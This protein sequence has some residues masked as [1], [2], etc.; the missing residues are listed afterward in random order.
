[1]Q[2]KSSLLLF[3]MLFFAN[4]FY[5]Q[6]G[7]GTTDPSPA[8]MLEVSSQSNG[9][10]DYK[11]FMPPR[12][13]NIAARDAIAPTASDYGLLVFVENTGAATSCLQLWIGDS[14]ADVSCYAI[15]T[16]PVATDVEV[17]GT[18][19]LGDMVTASFSYSDADGDPAGA[20]TYTWYI[21][22]DALG[23]GQT[24][25]QTGTSDTYTILA[26]HDTKYIA[27]AVTPVATSGASPGAT[28][29]SDYRGP[30]SDG[31]VWPAV[32]NFEITPAAFELPLASQTNGYF[33]TGTGSFPS[34]NMFVSP[35]RGYGA[36]NETGTVTLGPIDVSSAVDATFRLRL[37]S[38]AG[39][40]GN[41]ADPTDTVII[42]VST[43][44]GSTYSDELLVK[45][46][47]INRRWDFSASGSATTGYTGTNTAVEFASPGGASGISS[48]EITGI[49][50]AANLYIKVEMLNNS[51]NE[52]WVID[53]AEIWG[54]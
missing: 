40:S 44:G 30:I 5:A 53:D 26:A 18:L 35:D 37:A 48:L 33:T 34:S 4:N 32:Q 23:T 1:M 24:L 11:G 29:L 17:I 51:N 7:I 3:A 16:P 12:V 41:G 27:V 15:N 47:S 10:G 13:P 43:D 49:P 42:S 45:G 50:N 31:P 39:S 54:N 38:F 21:A 36:N 2:I 28:V 9:T 14:W 25:V 8:A 22:D 46:N 20:H 6:V 52:T 19:G